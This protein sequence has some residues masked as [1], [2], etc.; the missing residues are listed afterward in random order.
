MDVEEDKYYQNHYPNYFKVYHPEQKISDLFQNNISTFLGDI[1]KKYGF[2]KYNTIIAQSVENNF[3]I[4]S[5]EDPYQIPTTKSCGLIS[6]ALE[7][8][9]MGSGHWAAWVYFPSLKHLYLYDSM[10]NS[11]TSN[12]VTNFKRILKILFPGATV[13]TAPCARC[14]ILSRVRIKSESRQP[15]GGFV[16]NESSIIRKAIET[17]TPLSIVNYKRLTGYYAQHHY[18][19]AEA[20]MFLEDAMKENVSRRCKNPRDALIQVKS[21]MYTKLHNKYPNRNFSTFMKVYN[22]NTNRI[23]NVP[24]TE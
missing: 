19:F 9:A 24:T 12:F 20:L 13:S 3:H 6:L 5:H 11:G 21:Y 18:C 8:E 14:K 16:A 15:T 22:P 7:G 2:K 10:M 23:N 1:A 17:D 4:S